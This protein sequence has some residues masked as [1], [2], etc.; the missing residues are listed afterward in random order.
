[1]KKLLLLFLLAISSLH[2]QTVA[3]AVNPLAGQITATAANCQTAGACVW[4]KLPVDAATVGVT[5]A[6]SFT[7]TLAIEVSSDGGS[8]FATISSFTTTQTALPITVSGMTDLRVRASA[9]TSGTAY[10]TLNAGKGTQGSV[11][12]L[13]GFSDPCTNPN[14][15][16]TSAAINI[17]TATTT[18]LVAPVAA[19]RVYVCGFAFTISQVITTANTLTF[20]TG[21]GATCGT[22]TVTNS[23]P[24]GAGGVTA[25][26]PLAIA[27]GGGNQ[28]VFSSASG[29]GVCATTAIGATGSFAGMITFIQQ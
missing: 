10:V 26:I 22:S 25:A 20:I 28:A 12:N 14:I 4:Q 19:Q 16:A 13:P 1:M 29:A 5:I 11:L 27:Y 18:A 24:F 3:N 17:S 6:G 8:T 2:A 9:Y 21:S 23:G 15:I 7:A